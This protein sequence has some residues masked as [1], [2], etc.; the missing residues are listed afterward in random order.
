MAPGGRATSR[1]MSN[2]LGLLSSYRSCFEFMKHPVQLKTV[3]TCFQ[4]MFF[5]KRAPKQ[6]GGCLD[7]PWIRHWKRAISVCSRQRRVMLARFG[8]YEPTRPDKCRQSMLADVFREPTL[9]ADSLGQCRCV[10]H[11]CRL[12][13]PGLQLT[14]RWRCRRNLL[15]AA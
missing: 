1:A 10:C 3:T 4:N 9:T 14:S 2:P 7:T 11:Q 13:C 12:V 8:R 6:K 15:P 5:S